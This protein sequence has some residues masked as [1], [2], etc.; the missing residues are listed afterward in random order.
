MPV[1][2]SRVPQNYA[3]D[4]WGG[5]YFGIND[6]G[7]VS[8][9]PAPGESS[10]VDL[11][12]LALDLLNYGLRLPVLVRFD[13]ILRHRVRSLCN[14]FG[15]AAENLSY[16]GGYR[17]IYP[18]KV[19]Q[20]RSVI[21]QIVAGGDD[22][23]GLEAGSKPELMAVLATAPVD[24][25]IVCNGY[26]D[27]EYIRLALIG[28]RLGYRVYIVIEK[29]SELDLVLSESAELG[30]EPLLG[31]RVRLAAVAAGKWQNSGGAKSKFGL[32]AAQVLRLVERLREKGCLHWLAL[33]H[34]HIGSQI[35]DLRD[36]HRGV[37]EAARYFVE[38][39]ALGAAIR[40]IDVGGG[41]GID[42]EGSR[43]RNDYS[44]NYGL[45]DYAREV[46]RPIARA[47]ALHGIDE[48]EVFSESGRAL[49]AHHAVLITD[50][51]EREPPVAELEGLLDDG[52]D[53][54]QRLLGLQR[55][56]ANGQPLQLFENARYL[57]AE[58]NERFASGAMTLRQRAAAE[59]L[60]YAI[61]QDIRSQLRLE[62]RLHRELLEPLEELLADRV[63]CNFSLF[64]S[65]PDV[66]AIEQI[67]PVMPLQ[68]LAEA[69]EQAALMHDLTCD[70]DGCIDAYV[71]QDGVE[72]T[73][74][75]HHTRA[76]ETY[77]LGIFLVGA[78]QEILG[79]MHNLF[80]DTD[81][82]SVSVDADG[83]YRVGRPEHGDAVD[84]L[85]RY[86]HFEP[87]A[88]LETYRQ[89]LRLQGVSENLVNVY[90]RE[91]S[92]GLQGYTYLKN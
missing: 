66:W 84:D 31:V 88:M 49:T 57:L 28:S 71:D 19:N 24:G 12:D 27:R 30:I 85:L 42:Y 38:L 11:H 35:P 53:V 8:V 23:V 56:V 32:S 68:R 41:L 4:R 82:V 44:A 6:K 89:R 20:Q 81:A 17:A 1:S 90:Y 59:N 78:Y 60:L 47:C 13:E 91:L 75:L 65:L 5:G 2:Q 63:F 16:G 62:S 54:L 15:D 83:S 86:V 34:S 50:L 39:H 67:F 70:S 33:L 37:D 18:I 92:R 46:L 55:E 22:C 69:P 7:H 48:P 29:L 9:C 3:V 25:A 80:G 40:V 36:I 64:Q 77:L 58:A 61:A 43:S 45:I 14:A 21:E 51:I 76:G 52:D 79:D 26:K 72:R 73:L 10:E 87:D 74:K